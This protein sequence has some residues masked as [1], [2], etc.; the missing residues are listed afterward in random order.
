VVQ[1][2]GRKESL[3]FPTPAPTTNSVDRSGA[4]KTKLGG[5]D[6]SEDEDELGGPNSSGEEIF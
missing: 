5:S 1:T 6:V 4:A 3:A 2:R